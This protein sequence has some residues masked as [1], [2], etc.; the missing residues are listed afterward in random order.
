MMVE[1]ERL[2]QVS[3]MM[4]SEAGGRYV[5]TEALT[6]SEAEYRLREIMDGVGKGEMIRVNDN[7]AVNGAHVITAKIIPYESLADKKKAGR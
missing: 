5:M 1:D 6:G 2:W 7:T 3:V 4:D